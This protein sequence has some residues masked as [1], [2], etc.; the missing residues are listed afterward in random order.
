MSKTIYTIYWLDKNLQPHARQEND[1]TAA[2]AFVEA[3]RKTA[4][5]KGYSAIT[6][7]SEVA[8]NV[9]KSGVAGVVDGK[10]PTGE[11]YTYTKGDALSQRTKKPA[12]GT[13]F[14][15]VDLDDE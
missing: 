7:S 9:G 8:G 6:M 5:E 11:T 1:L 2:L 14:I 10:L 3:K 13:D 12:V 15:V 4:A